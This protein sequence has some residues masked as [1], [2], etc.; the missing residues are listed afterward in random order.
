MGLVVEE[1]VILDGGA[2]IVHVDRP[3]LTS[4][5]A[6]SG[7][8]VA[9][10]VGAPAGAAQ[11]QAAAPFGGGVVGD[12]VVDKGHGQ[13]AVADID[14]AAP[15]VVVGCEDGVGLEGAGLQA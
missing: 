15:V 1:L 13:A 3:A 9:A 4:E 6:V 11:V 10:H 14:R 12:G 7:E 2:G 5:A 8:G